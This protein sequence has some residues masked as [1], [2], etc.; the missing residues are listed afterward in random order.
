MVPVGAGQTS[1]AGDK[2]ALRGSSPPEVQPRCGVPPSRLRPELRRNIS[3]LATQ[4]LLHFPLSTWTRDPSEKDRRAAQ[5]RG[6]RTGRRLGRAWV[7]QPHAPSPASAAQVA[8]V[9]APRP[10]AARPPPPCAPAPFPRRGSRLRRRRRQH[11]N[12]NTAGP[13]ASPAVLRSLHSPVRA[14]NGDRK[15]RCGN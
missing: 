10:P 1:G 6:A 5:S 12:I 3:Q 11:N 8:I 13:Q 4:P 9:P 15:A 7:P 14:G 2:S